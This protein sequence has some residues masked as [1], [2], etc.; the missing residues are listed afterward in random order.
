MIDS[1]DML[2]RKSHHD[3]MAHLF[4]VLTK[5]LRRTL[6]VAAKGAIR[7]NPQISQTRR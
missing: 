1:H 4:A 5:E 6:D 2:H 3:R 7:E